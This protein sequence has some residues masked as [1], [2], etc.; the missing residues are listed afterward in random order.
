MKDRVV[1]RCIDALFTCGHT[2]QQNMQ[3]PNEKNTNAS[4]QP[5]PEELAVRLLLAG[6]WSA[7]S[8]VTHGQKNAFG[9]VSVIYRIPIRQTIAFTINAHLLAIYYGIQYLTVWRKK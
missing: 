4:L 9:P 6:H 2:V 3:M 8:S 7:A 5:N 1:Q